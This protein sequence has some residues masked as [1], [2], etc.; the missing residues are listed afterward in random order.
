MIAQTHQIKDML[1]ED[2]AS[3]IDKDGMEDKEMQEAILHPYLPPKFHEPPKNTIYVI[4]DVKNAR[5]IYKELS[6]EIYGK[7]SADEKQ[8]LGV[9][10]DWN[11]TDR[12][13]FDLGLF[14]CNEL[15]WTTLRELRAERA[16]LV[17]SRTE[18]A[19]G[20]IG[21]HD[22]IEKSESAPT[23]DATADTSAQRRGLDPERHSRS[24]SR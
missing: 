1:R 3:L 22:A 18:R 8:H 15:S 2:R 13:M 20:Q 24:R 21:D 19:A 9:R 14:E 10:P 5:A 17:Q 23:S 16:A 6:V 4:T 12:E 11:L 7:L